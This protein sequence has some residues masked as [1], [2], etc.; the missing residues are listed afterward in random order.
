[1][2]L[3]R[4]EAELTGEV[5][6]GTCAVCFYLDERGEE[7]ATRLRRMLASRGIKYKEL[8]AKLRADAEEPT[9]EWEAL[10]RHARGG[11]AAREYLRPQEPKR[12][13]GGTVPR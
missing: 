6:A 12:A 9:I 13:G 7:W 1:M 5:P 3:D 4:I 10:S 11:C 8:A 2:A